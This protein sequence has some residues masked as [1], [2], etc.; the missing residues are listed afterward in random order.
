MIN[1]GHRNVVGAF[2][3]VLLAACSSE[4]PPTPAPT[5]RNQAPAE[6]T[7]PADTRSESPKGSTA[8]GPGDIALGMTEKQVFSSDLLKHLAPVAAEKPCLRGGPSGFEQGK[9]Y[10][11]PA[12]C[13]EIASGNYESIEPTETR[14]AKKGVRISGDANILGGRREVELVFDRGA[15]SKIT[16]QMGRFSKELYADATAALKQRYKMGEFTEAELSDFDERRRECVSITNDTNQ[17]WL[18]LQRVVVGTINTKI[19]YSSLDDLD[20]NTMKCT[21]VAIRKR[22]SVNKL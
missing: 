11:V 8:V 14:A 6:K 12:D 15:L 13:N 19:V 1:V 2:A 5:V 17:V 9:E 10:W 16:I 3:V 4:A 20:A 21:A 7:S 22:D 18:V